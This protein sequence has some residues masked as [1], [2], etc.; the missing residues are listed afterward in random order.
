MNHIQQDSKRIL[1]ITLG[2]FLL[3]IATNAILIPNKLLSGGVSGIA[4]F[5]H[6][7]FN[8][9][10]SA[11]ILFLNIPL[12]ILAL[13][14]LKKK[15]IVYS[16][17]GMVMLSVWI[18]ITQNF[19]IP[20]GNLVSVILVGGVL[21]GLGNG[22]IFKG[23]GSTGGIDIISKILNQRL[24]ISMATINLSINGV[25]LLF[26]IMV[27]GIDL[28]VLTLATMFVSSR[29]TNFVVD[30]IHYKRTLFIITD[31]EHYQAISSAILEEIHRGVTVIPSIGAYTHKTKYILYT[32]IGIQEVAKVKQI[33]MQYDK[34]AFMTVSETSQVIGNGRG[35]VHTDID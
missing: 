2:T 23:D 16:L 25:I 29:V 30:G 7:L 9:N 3:A 34:K 22:I 15:F 12:F 17:Y 14:F 31:E 32:T 8:T 4:M 21:N 11:T 1:F 5:L 10:V 35:F 6:F 26:S 19:I 33:V 24:S 20:T 18:E 27:F 13:F 28:S